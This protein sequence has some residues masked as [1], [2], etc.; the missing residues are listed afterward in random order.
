MVGKAAIAS[1]AMVVET[2]VRREL[3]APPVA[4]PCT[5]VNVTAT[6]LSSTLTSVDAPSVTSRPLWAVCS[7]PSAADERHQ[8]IPTSGAVTERA[9][10]RINNELSRVRPFTAHLVPTEHRLGPHPAG[11]KPSQGTGLTPAKG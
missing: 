5:P 10:S 7:Y 3:G 1:F 11:T 2:P 9:M 4:V 8:K 6:V